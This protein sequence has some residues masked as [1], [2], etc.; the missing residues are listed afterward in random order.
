MPYVLLR[1]S[2]AG[3]WRAY[4][5]L[6]GTSNQLLA[7]LTFLGIT[8]W[9]KKSG[10]PFWFTLWPMVFVLSIT[11]W[12]LVAQARA[13]FR[14]SLA[15]NPVTINGFA[16]LLLGALTAMLIIESLVTLRRPAETRPA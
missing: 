15:F 10:K 4:W 14:Q 3:S 2:E 5:T 7:G 11:V 9:L 16:A 1:A 13:A 12:S 6:F 8:V